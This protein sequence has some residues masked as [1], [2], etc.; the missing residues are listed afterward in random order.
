MFP[1]DI[2]EDEITPEIEEEK[3]PSDYEIDLET[4]KLT[5]RIISGLD[6]IKQYVMIVLRTDRYFYPQ[7]SW[8]HGCDL[9]SLIGQHYD[10]EYIK[11]EVKRMLDEALLIKSDVIGIEDLDCKIVRDKL[12]C[13]FTLDTV[14]GRA[15]I[16]V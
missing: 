14:Y 8:D 11:S 12:I 6:A 3:I 2:D 4:G 7:Y 5:G 13:S 10:D 1:F 15:E 16:N 9:N